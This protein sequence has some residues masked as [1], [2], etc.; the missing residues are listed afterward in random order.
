[1]F[2]T[3]SIKKSIHQLKSTCILLQ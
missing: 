3:A 1:M 2:L